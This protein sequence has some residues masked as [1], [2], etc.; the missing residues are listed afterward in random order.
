MGEPLAKERVM[1]V[2]IVDD[3]PLFR[4]GVAVALAGDERLEFVL[5]EAGDG[6]KLPSP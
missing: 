3:D 1:R 5:S 2:L 4:L 6:A